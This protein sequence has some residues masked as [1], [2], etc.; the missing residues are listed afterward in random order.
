[1]AYNDRITRANAKPLEAEQT[2]INEIIQGV[3]ENSQIL[4]LAT[5]LPNMTASQAKMAVLA[6]L[7][8]AYFVTDDGGLKQTTKLAWKNKFIYA[9]ELAVIVP[10]AKAVLDDASYDIW[11]QVKPRIVEAMYKKIDEAIITGKGKPA[12]WRDGLIPSIINAGNNVTYSA[13]DNT[14]IKISKAMGKVEADGF[15]VT[16]ILGGVGLKQAFREGLR[17]TTGQPLANSEVTELPRK[18]V[19]NGAWDSTVNFIVGDFKQLVYSIRDDITFDV[20]DSGVITDGSGNIIFNLIQQDMLALRVTF[21]LGYELPNS[22]N[23][24]NPDESTRF[25]FALVENSSAP[26]TYTVTFTVTDTSSSAVQNAIITF[27]GQVLKTNSSGQAVFKSLGNA[28]YL[29]SVEKDGA[30]TVFGKKDVAT[31]NTTV[32][33]ENF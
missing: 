4:P 31:S 2:I 10:I 11:G 24:V 5:R 19:K 28:S 20:F 26:T 16:G 13:D 30:Q 3:V 22:I 25:P 27:G 33:V 17:D 32:A 15:D 29:Y 9:E 23:A 1:M 6:G 8:E 21:R 12:N 18:Y 14:F 7:P